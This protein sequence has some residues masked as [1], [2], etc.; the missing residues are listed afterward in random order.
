MWDTKSLIKLITNLDQV[1]YRMSLPDGNYEFMSEGAKKVFGYSYQKFLN[2]PLFIKKI[3]HPDFKEYFQKKWADLVNG[4][5]PNTSEY[6]IIDVNNNVRWILQSNSGIY[7]EENNIIAI[8]GICIDI[9]HEKMAVKRSKTLDYSLKERLKELDFLYN[10]SVLLENRKLS[11]DQILWKTLDLIATAFQYS[12]T[13]NSKII[14]DKKVYI[15]EDFEKSDRRLHIKEN[16]YDKNLE[17]FIYYKKDRIFLEEER[18]L[19][20]ELGIRLKNNLKHRITEEKYRKLI[21]NAQEG[22]WTLDEKANTSFVNKRMAEM[23]GYTLEEM[24]GKSLFDFID[25]E[26]VSRAKFLFNRRKKGL[27]EIHEFQFLHKKGK[28]IYTRMN[29]F[30]IFNN[31][32]EF[33]NAVAFVSDITKI[34]KAEIEAT[35]NRRR[36]EYL[37]NHSPATIYTAEVQNDY[38]ATFISKNVKKMTGYDRRE[39]LGDSQFWIDH[40][41]PEDQAIVYKEV[42]MIFEKDFHSYNYRFRCKDGKYIWVYDSMELVRDK[43]GKP[44]EIVGFW[45]DITEL[46]KAQ[47]KLKKSEEKYRILIENQSDLVI[48]VDLEGRLLFVSPSYCKLFGKSE[49]QLLGK[50][51]MPLIHEE[52]RENTFRAMKKLYEPP[53]SSHI[54]QRALTKNG[55]RYL[56]WVNT[57]ILDENKKVKEII[58]VGRDITEK[59]N[60][61]KRLEESEEKYRLITEKA[62]DL[63]EITDKK[64]KIEFINQRPHK[65]ILGYT[66]DDV[67]GKNLFDFTHPDTRKRKKNLEKK[68]SV[69]Y[70]EKPWIRIRKKN[71]KY[72]WTEIK[73]SKFHDNEANLKYLFIGR[74]ITENKKLIEEIQKQNEELKRI[75]KIREDLFESLSH[76]IRTPITSIKGYS[77]LLLKNKNITDNQQAVEDIETIQRNITK[78]ERLAI[79]MINYNEF[80]RD[81]VSYEKNNFKVSEIIKNIKKD[82]KIK[83]AEKDLDIID[84]Y[85]PDAFLNLDEFQISK[86]IKNL[87][88]NA[89]KFSYPNSKIMIN[90]KV[91]NRS[92]TF[93]IRDHGVGME[94]DDLKILFSRVRRSVKSNDIIKEGLGIGLTICKKIVD[95]YN[96]KI[97]AKSFGLGKGSKFIFTIPL[98]KEKP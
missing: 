62:H 59:K 31:R 3:I 91:E 49:K 94:K 66:K 68:L 64:F 24:L 39:F 69:E 26:E 30:P 67:V 95:H 1:Y 53:Y 5:I 7:N 44:I 84:T 79:E 89:I 81:L 9:T 11:I 90:S 41:H 6:K 80:Q 34:K 85:R 8:E 36:L 58:G 51:F 42:P 46:K 38:S 16:I 76:E 23:L 60:A 52:D 97:W 28:P 88:D 29:T 21:E 57:A 87:I 37:L 83:L 12:E 65:E 96:G 71:G 27:K 14:Y 4:I 92:W 74:D 43:T 25:K 2:E 22:I 19:I 20:N 15:K 13:I 98:D 63:I 48:K 45:R 35:K 47:L 77:E 73:I 32:G 56:E 86:L 70:K 61:L 72:I 50:K 82:L 75:D 55:W 10:L 33:S 78:L 40:I 18:D 54:E 17:I 93:S